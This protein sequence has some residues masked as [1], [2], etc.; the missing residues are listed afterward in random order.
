MVRIRNNGSTITRETNC[1]CICVCL[2]FISCIDREAKIEQT[3]A[4]STHSKAAAIL[5]ALQP[6]TLMLGKMEGKKRKGHQR[7]RWLNDIPD[8]MDMN[9]S[10]LQE[11][12]KDKE[13]WCALAHE[14][15]KRGHDLVTQKQQQQGCYRGMGPMTRGSNGVQAPLL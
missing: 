13:A 7:M 9:L 12:A 2:V 4:R 6:A 14:V 11:I 10:K 15:T 1:L 3:E 8:S 5:G